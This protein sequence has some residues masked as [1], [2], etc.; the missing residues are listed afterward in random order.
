MQF[1]QAQIAV[2]ENSISEIHNTNSKLIQNCFL[3]L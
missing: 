3:V 2:T 1:G